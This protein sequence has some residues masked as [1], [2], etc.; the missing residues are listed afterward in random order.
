MQNCNECQNSKSS[1]QKGAG[2]LRPFPPTD[3][4][5][6]VI[7]MDFIFKLLKSD[8]N[9]TGVFLVVD[10]LSKRVR[11]IPVKSEI[12]LTKRP[13]IYFRSRLTIY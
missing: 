5:W 6:K 11:C 1:N 13:N 4:K 2:L 12:M 9:D 7:S 10:R 8:N 3:K